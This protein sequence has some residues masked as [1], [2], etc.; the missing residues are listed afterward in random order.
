MRGIQTGRVAIGAM[1]TMGPV[2]ISLVLAGFHE[3]H[4]QR[5]ADRARGQQRRARRDAARR[6]ARPRVPVRHRADREPRPG[7]AAD[8]DR[9]G[10]RRRAAA[11]P[12]ARRPRGD[13]DGRARRRAVHQLP[14]GRPA[15]RAAG[16]RRRTRSAS[17]RRSCSS[18]T[19]PADPAARG[20][21]LGVAILPRSHAIGAGTPTRSPSLRLIEPAAR[22]RHHAGVA[23]GARLPPAVAEFLNLTRETFPPEGLLVPPET[24]GQR[25]A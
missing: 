3:L 1:H 10:A 17:R 12:P 5:R 4:P 15:A 20:R 8:P 19:R 9:R 16:R 13:P 21:G 11:G 6:R 22:P 24:A 14:R 2:D 23:L 7:A 25:A 18:P